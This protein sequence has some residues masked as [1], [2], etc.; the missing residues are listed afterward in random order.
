[1]NLA[2]FVLST[3]WYGYIQKTVWAL[4]LDGQSVV[5]DRTHTLMRCTLSVDVPT[6]RSAARSKE[7]RAVLYTNLLVG[8]L[9]F[10]QC[11]WPFRHVK[12]VTF[13]CLEVLPI[14]RKNGR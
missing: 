1:M 14:H 7:A 3:L 8:V 5:L 11:S 2:A 12:S 10:L 4:L 6:H 13:P 9:A